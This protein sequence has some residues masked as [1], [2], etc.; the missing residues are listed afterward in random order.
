MYNQRALRRKFSRKT[1]KDEKHDHW[2]EF[3]S[4]KYDKQLIEDIKRVLAGRVFFLN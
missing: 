3:A 2:L 4:D 1:P